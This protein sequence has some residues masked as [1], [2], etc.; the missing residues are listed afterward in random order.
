[1]AP[2]KLHLGSGHKYLDGW[3]NVDWTDRY[4][5]DITA[6][7]LRDGFWNS[8]AP[9]SIESVKSEHFVEHIPHELRH[10]DKDGLIWFMESIYRVCK[11]GAEVEIAFPHHQGSW[12]YGDPTHCRFVQGATFQY[13][14]R[15]LSAPG[16]NYPDYGINADFEMTSSTRQ[17]MI[18]K[19]E[20]NVTQEEAVKRSDREWNWF[21][22]ERVFLK[23]HK[24]MRIPL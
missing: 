6:N 1:M 14:D 24:P 16:G 5:V 21:Y 13:F 8:L 12:A 22:E 3:T 18:K 17:L 20:A 4:K 15:V 10:T 2:T 11:H 19:D 23:A 9:D 7:I